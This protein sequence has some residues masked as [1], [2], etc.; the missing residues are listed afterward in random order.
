M[1]LRRIRVVASGRVQGVFFRESTRREASRRGVSGWAEN[2]A[3]GT[4]ECVFEGAAE[5]VAA[6]EAFVREGPGQARVTSVV[7]EAEP[8]AGLSGFSVR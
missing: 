2:R 5:A 7:V 3:D 8:V 1:G 6:L 4:V